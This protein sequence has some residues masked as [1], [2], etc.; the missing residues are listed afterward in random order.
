MKFRAFHH[1]YHEANLSE[2]VIDPGRQIT[3]DMDLNPYFNKVEQSARVTFDGI[4]NF[5]EVGAF[6]RSLPKPKRLGA[7]IA[8]IS[9]LQYTG[10][11][12]NWVFMELDSG[13]IIIR[14]KHVYES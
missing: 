10:S 6:F 1:I 9:A 4:E 2:F 7:P 14:A 11:G 13:H 3:L 5:D 12:P 8:E